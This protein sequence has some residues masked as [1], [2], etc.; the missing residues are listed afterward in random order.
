MESSDELRQRAERYRRMALSVSDEQAIETLKELAAEFDALA[1]T[2][3]AGQAQGQAPLG[4]MIRLR[5]ANPIRLTGWCR[6]GTLGVQ[7]IPALLN[8]PCSLGRSARPSRRQI[9][10]S[11]PLGRP[12]TPASRPESFY[13]PG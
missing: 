1:A 13:C 11:R 5:G 9:R 10:L 12:G 2:L 7:E 8:A 6:R 3:D 4:R